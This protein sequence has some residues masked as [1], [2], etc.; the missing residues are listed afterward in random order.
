M[1]DP[2][3]FLPHKIRPCAK[4]LDSSVL[5][6]AILCVKMSLPVNKKLQVWMKLRA[7]SST[8]PMNQPVSV[9][10]KIS[11]FNLFLLKH[12]SFCCYYYCYSTLVSVCLLLRHVECEDPLS[13][14]LCVI[15]AAAGAAALVPPGVFQEQVLQLQGRCVVVRHCAVGDADVWWV[16]SLK[17]EHPQWPNDCRRDWY[18]AD[19]KIMGVLSLCHSFLDLPHQLSTDGS[20][21]K[22]L[23]YEIKWWVVTSYIY[24]CTFKRK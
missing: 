2:Q 4:S 22:K 16:D 14:S 5:H 20:A 13:C 15:R 8:T 23:K 19:V 12:C 10:A 11:S 18:E 17:S 7:E 1:V 6:T 24:F 3:T 9:S 21:R